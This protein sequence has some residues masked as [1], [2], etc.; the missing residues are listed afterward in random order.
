VLLDGHHR[1]EICDR[2]GI[3]YITREISLPGRGDARR[4]IIGHQFARRNLTPY[5]RAELALELKPLLA[6]EAAQRVGGRPRRDAEEPVQNSGR[7]RT[8]K[9]L[10]RV[11][12]V[13][14]DTIVKVDSGTQS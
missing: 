13:S 2:Y 8:D 3:G 5:Q 12:E 1:K 14:H 6:A 9:E 7:V 4:W 10:A 11:A